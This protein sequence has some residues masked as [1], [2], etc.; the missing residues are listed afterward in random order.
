MRGHPTGALGAAGVHGRFGGAARWARSG[1]LAA[2]A[3]LSVLAAGCAPFSGPPSQPAPIPDR[4]IDLQGHCQQTE[5]DGF[6]EAAELIVRDN[7]VQ[8]L[9]WQLWVG[10]R[11]QCRFDASRF[12]QVKARPHIELAALDGS[13]CKLMIWQEPQKITLAHAGCEAFCTPGIYEDAW[14]VSFDSRTG[15]CAQPQ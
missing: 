12:R 1:V 8:V 2:V 11:G 6:R 4:A 5:E 9:D 10:R 13:A 14:P 7:R 15:G 3:A